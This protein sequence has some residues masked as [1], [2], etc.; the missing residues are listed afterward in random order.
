MNSELLKEAIADAKAVRATALAN[1][2]VALEEA[3]APRF[4]AMFADKLKEEAEEAQQEESTQV[5]EVEAAHNVSKAVPTKDVSKGQPKKMKSGTPYKPVQ[6]GEGPDGVGKL[7][8]PVCETEVVADMDE[9]VDEAGLTSEDLDEIIK[10]LEAEVAAEAEGD[11]PAMAP[12]VPPTDVPPAPAPGGDGCP[13]DA[14]PAPMAPPGAPVPPMAP[15]MAPPAP[16][17]APP[18]DGSA[19]PVPGD[20]EEINLEELIAS[21][22]ETDEEVTEGKLPPWLKKDKK[23]DDKEDKKDDKKDKDE[24]CESSKEN[25]MPAPDKGQ[26]KDKATMPNAKQGSKNHGGSDLEHTPKMHESEALAKENSELKASLQEHIEAVEFLRGQI[27]EV[28]LLNAKLLYTNKLFKEFA[29]ILDDKKRM[30]IVEHFDLTKNVR[31]V[32]LAYAVLAESLNFGVKAPAA[33]PKKVASKA[34]AVVKQITEGLASKPVASTAPSK[35]I[36]SES[37]AMASRFQK[38][39]GIKVQPPKK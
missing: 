3:F 31:E 23:D 4:H 26:A 8:Q 5:A 32:K 24:M 16:P 36:L 38:L 29:S 13:C 30:K 25:G 7:H 11:E 20:D 34:P 27:N 10:E 15:P 33:E 39:A 14:A 9:N 28:N 19:P 35:E 12:E 22:N 18:V 2:K 6:A 37:A 1:A 17:M 21:L